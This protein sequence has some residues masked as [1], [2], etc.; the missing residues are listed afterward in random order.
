M[1]KRKQILVCL[2]AFDSGSANAGLCLTESEV[3]EQ[4]DT[5]AGG[6]AEMCLFVFMRCSFLKVSQQSTAY[7]QLGINVGHTGG[8]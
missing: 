6:V 8:S 4:M 7:V 1:K 5:V 2:L 3:Q